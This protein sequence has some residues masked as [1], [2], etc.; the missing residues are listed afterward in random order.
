MRNRKIAVI[1]GPNINMLGDRETFV[2]GFE[3]WSSIEAKVKELGN[4][5]QI[6]VIFFQSNYEGEIIEFIQ[7]NVRE[8]AGVVIN[9]A[10]LS[11][12]GYGILDALNSLP[13][14]YVEVHL[15]NIVCRGSWHAESVFTENAIGFIMG[16]K[17]CVYELGLRAINY[18]LEEQKNENCEKQ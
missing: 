17:G 5:L 6:D 8:F 1:N 9:P 18:Y 2:Y 16:L 12:T 4:Q 3:K 14:P 7:K 11:K 15:S 10:S 13:I